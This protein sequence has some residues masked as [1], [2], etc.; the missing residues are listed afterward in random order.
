[1]K[2]V[3]LASAGIRYGALVLVAVAFA[4]P[5]YWMVVTSLN[6]PDTLFDVPPRL[7]PQWDWANYGEA[8]R[9]VN[10]IGYLL[11]TVLIAGATTALVVATSVLAG[12]AF[13]AMNF[14]GKPLVFAFI[15]G[16]YMVPAEVTL[17]PNFITLA[18][19]G[20][21]NRSNQAGQYLAQIV[22]FGASIFGIFLLRQFFLT[23]P[24][25]LWEAAQLDGCSHLRFLWT[26]AVPLARPALVTVALFHFVAG[27][28]AF[29]WP[30]I[31]TS[32]DD[33]RPIQVGVAF[34]RAAESSQYQLQAA[35]ALIATLPVLVIFMFAQKQLIGGIA[36]TGI[37]G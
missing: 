26:I 6:R 34:F 31:V 12:Y 28:N 25:D 30:L 13:A 33:V 8:W 9:T 2:P 22:P 4:F 24:R 1:V 17:V 18:N 10:W 11:N 35:G 36:S 32:R 3:R 14:P 15:L 27:W 23:L 21:L 7:V 20:W 37:R 19:L 5:F 29:I 16:L